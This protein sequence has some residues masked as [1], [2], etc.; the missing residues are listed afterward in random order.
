[1]EVD[2]TRDYVIKYTAA[3]A[4]D[5]A[6]LIVGLPAGVF[7]DVSGWYTYRHI[8]TMPLV[9]DADGTDGSGEA[10]YGYLNVEDNQEITTDEYRRIIWG[11]LKLNKGQVFTKTIKTD[12]GYK[13]GR[14]PYLERASYYSC[15]GG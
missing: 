5:K 4:L 7:S 8:D 9:E 12:A 11:P 10:I 14:H 6:Y 13:R 1:M 2:S 15:G 3:T